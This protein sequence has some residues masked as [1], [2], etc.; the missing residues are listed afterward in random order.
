M[1]L[2]F[3]NIYFGERSNFDFDFCEYIFGETFCPRY[4]RM[5]RD[6]KHVRTAGEK[7]TLLSEIQKLVNE[8][9]FSFP[10]HKPLGISQ[11]PLQPGLQVRDKIA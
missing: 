5:Y 1:T 7:K 8:Q 2:T 6:P 10:V 11:M 9:R 3:A 4:Q